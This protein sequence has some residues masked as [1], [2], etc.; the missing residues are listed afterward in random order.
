M[1][2]C[3]MLRSGN[4]QSQSVRTSQA[5]RRFATFI[6]LSQ[7]A[8]PMPEPDT[9]ASRTTPVMLEQKGNHQVRA[10]GLVLQSHSPKKALE[11]TFRT[12]AIQQQ[13]GFE[14]PENV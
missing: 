5:E 2:A 3:G 6:R 10:R 11:T 7:P 8:N 13:V 1:S 4:G 14:R 12:Q 9:L